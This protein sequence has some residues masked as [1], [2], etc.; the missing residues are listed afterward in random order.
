[1]YEKKSPYNSNANFYLNELICPGLVSIVRLGLIDISSK[2]HI[3]D[4]KYNILVAL[5]I[6][7][8]HG[9]LT[10]ELGHVLYELGGVD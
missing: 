8:V 10:L 4:I 1:M 5:V 6:M 2:N 7:R 3:T 9:L